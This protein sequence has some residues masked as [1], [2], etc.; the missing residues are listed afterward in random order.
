VPSRGGPIQSAEH[1]ARGSRGRSAAAPNHP[2]PPARLLF[3]ANAVA[4]TRRPPA[5]PPQ[6]G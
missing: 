1:V 5:P 3:L 4:R 2:Y 6:P